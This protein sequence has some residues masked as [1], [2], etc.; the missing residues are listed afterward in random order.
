MPTPA[1]IAIE[2]LWHV[3]IATRETESKLD[4]LQADLGIGPWAV[5]DFEFP[6]G[7]A[8]VFGERVSMRVKAAA[9][10]SGFLMFGFD[11]PES[12][13]HPFRDLLAR[14]SSGAHH[15]ACLVKDIAAAR[16][17]LRGFGYE[18]VLASDAVGP[19]H[20][21]QVS[22]FDATADL[23]THIE[24]SQVNSELPMADFHRNGQMPPSSTVST[25][26]AAYVSIVVP[27]AARAAAAFSRVLGAAPAQFSE[28]TADGSRGGVAVRSTE[29]VATLQMGSWVLRLVEPRTPG[30][31]S[32]D[33]LTQHG[34]GIH[35][36][37]FNVEDVRSSAAALKTKGYR[38]TWSAYGFG[39]ARSDA[40]H[41]ATEEALGI[42]IELCHS[43]G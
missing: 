41:F 19:L 35:A 28:R 40:A 33:F 36:F 5:L 2:Q 34:P 29:N 21:S 17:S 1:P 27:D 39:A 7:T 31:P 16:R 15:L 3:A 43:P 22:Y 20:D 25:Q 13:P 8:T 32:H 12:D 37:G 9:G 38:E 42:D 26:G 24:V 14:R 10:Q 4:R 30:S 23:G 6:P 11:Q 18:E